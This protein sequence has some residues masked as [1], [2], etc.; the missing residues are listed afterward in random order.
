MT[1]LTWLNLIP[2]PSFAFQGDAPDT[3]P[4]LFWNEAMEVHSK[5]AAELATNNKLSA[6]SQRLLRAQQRN[7]RSANLG[8][9]GTFDFKGIDGGIVI[10]SLAA[11]GNREFE[12][13]KVMFLAMAAHDLRSPLRHIQGLLDEVREG[14]RDMGDGKLELL[15]MIEDVGERARVFTNDVITYTWATHV[16][17][18][19]TT[20]IELFNLANEIFFSVDP[21]GKHTL[22]CPQLCVETDRLALQIALRNLFDNAVRHGGKES[23]HITLETVDMPEIK[24]VR[25]VVTDDGQGTASPADFFVTATDYRK[26]SS[27]GLLGIKRLIEERGGEISAIELND[28][29]GSAITFTLPGFLVPKEEGQSKAG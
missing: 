2:A 26:S 6:L 14:F 18:A 10:A 11:R 3:A 27:F 21:H 16:E 1:D 5:V 15:N 23:M 25:F 28:K 12:D 19:Q 20:R 4:I 8:S 7:A 29:P 17:Q 24:S 22:V 13:E 9:L